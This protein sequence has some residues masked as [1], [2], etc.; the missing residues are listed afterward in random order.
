M[1]YGLTSEVLKGAF[2]FLTGRKTDGGNMVVGNGNDVIFF[3]SQKGY[4]VRRSGVIVGEG[5]GEAVA[6]E[7]SIRLNAAFARAKVL[8]IPALLPEGVI[9]YHANNQALNPNKNYLRTQVSIIGK[10][11][12]ISILKNV[13]LDGWDSLMFGSANGV[14]LAHF[15]MHSTF[16]LDNRPEGNAAI[17][18]QAPPGQS[19][20]DVYIHDLSFKNI[21][22]G[23]ILLKR[24]VRPIV[25]NIHADTTGAD[26]VHFAG[27]SQDMTAENISSRNAGDDTVAFV[28]YTAGD[29]IGRPSRG[30]AS[31]IT[32]IDPR[33]GRGVA[34]I[35]GYDIQVTNLFVSNCKSSAFIVG[36]ESGYPSY[37]SDNVS[38][39]NIIAI[40]C[41]GSASG[42]IQVGS[43][44]TTGFE[45]DNVKLSDITVKNAVNRGFTGINANNL[46]IRNFTVVG[47]V[48]ECFHFTKCSNLDLV[49]TKAEEGN[50]HGY[51]FRTSC[52]GYL[53]VNGLEIRNVSKVGGS[54]F[55]LGMEPTATPFF[56]M[57]W[58]DNFKVTLQAFGMGSVIRNDMHKNVTRYGQNIST[59]RENMAGGSDPYVTGIVT[60]PIA[61]VTPVDTPTEW[62]NNTGVIQMVRVTGTTIS[63]IVIEVDANNSV[64]YAKTTGYFLV[65]PGR[66]ITITCSAAAGV[67]ITRRPLSLI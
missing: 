13:K 1:N 46:S 11:R 38:A 25:R 41:G 5:V 45:I 28:G 30:R 21:S 44:T 32:V 26:I 17:K 33:H 6:I 67:V 39:S 54:A 10:G 50:S 57:V 56:S 7:N 16:K 49:N 58:I 62:V 63:S 60:T 64:P 40:N 51:I 35:G 36:G 61:V 43:E 12:D 52:F 19:Y 29:V 53:N 59:V 37:K 2:N 14:E 34:V 3:D 24:C 9:E 55:G 4:D 48:G 42:A 47:A 23:C 66:K 8:G 20:D 31:N 27:E 18:F 22:G 65:H 15:S